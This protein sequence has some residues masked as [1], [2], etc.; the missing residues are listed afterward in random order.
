MTAESTALFILDG[1]HFF[2]TKDAGSPW[3]DALI[4]G[5]PVAG[6]L[7]NAIEQL[8]DNPMHQ[9]ARFTVDLMRP[10]PRTGLSVTRRILRSGKRLQVLEAILN[11]DG[12]EVSRAVAQVVQTV[13]LDAPPERDG[14]A[15]YVGPDDLAESSLLPPPLTGNQRAWGFHDVVGVRWVSPRNEP[16]PNVLWIRMPLSLVAGEPL[17][18][19]IR[20]VS[21]VD[22][23]SSVSAHALN[24]PPPPPGG[25][26][27]NSDLTLYLYRPL[28]GEWLG[29]ECE[30]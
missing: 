15:P 7:A 8:I 30:R 18:P 27:I 14:V 24:P 21:A 28:N 26:W 3:G 17:S 23:I 6:L 5:G 2:P 1:A 12:V 10:V 11:A 4:G 20:V 13:A 16:G 29:L 9:I 19:L 22:F 25:R